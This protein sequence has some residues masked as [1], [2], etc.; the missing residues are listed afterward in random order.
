MGLDAVEIV[1]DVEEHFGVTIRNEDAGTIRTVGEL[2]D[3]I[4]DRVK[5][6]EAAG[7]LSLPWFLKLRRLTREAAQQPGLRIRPSNRV[8][9]VLRANQR[10]QLWLGL[11]GYLGAALPE[12]RRPIPISAIVI[13]MAI[14]SP[15]FLAISGI[16]LQTNLAVASI[17]CA[18][19]AVL[20]MTVTQR[21]KVIPPRGYQTF[22]AITQRLVGLEAVTNGNLAAD[23]ELILKDL[24]QIVSN[25]LNVKSE[26]VTPEARFIEDLGVG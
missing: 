18:V 8:D 11:D 13:L 22:G 26:R 7:C 1:M 9:R 21:L 2:I 4:E 10:K 19:G 14:A 20:L 6:R 17:I 23:R 3:L 24:A 5:R 12:L 16:T 25:I 15:V